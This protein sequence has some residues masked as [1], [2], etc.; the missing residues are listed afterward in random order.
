MKYFW[1]DW[2]TPQLRQRW[3]S[4]VSKVFK[5]NQCPVLSKLCVL[6]TVAGPSASLHMVVDSIY[7][8]SVFF[9]ML[10]LSPVCASIMYLEWWL[11]AFGSSASNPWFSFGNPCVLLSWYTGFCWSWL[12]P[13]LQGLPGA[14]SDFLGHSDWLRA[15]HVTQLGPIRYLEFFLRHLGL[16]GT[17][18][19]RGHMGGSV[20]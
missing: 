2:I 20:G 7:Q 17:L 12:Y 15:E 9:S 14:K 18:I 16:A 5:A 19:K 13:K 10:S 3:G 4:I 1:S 11:W 8:V 6:C